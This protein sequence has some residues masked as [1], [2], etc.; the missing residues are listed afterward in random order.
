MKLDIPSFL[1]G[2]NSGIGSGGY[3]K[4]GELGRNAS[5]LHSYDASKVFLKDS[6]FNDWA[7]STT[8]TTLDNGVAYDAITIDTTENDFIVLGKWHTHFE[9]AS[10]AEE[11]ARI[12]DLYTSIAHGIR[13]FPNTIANMDTETISSILVDA[14]PI[15][16]NIIDY[17]NS[18]G[19]HTITVGN[20]GVYPQWLSPTAS[21]TGIIAKTPIV[22]GKCGTASFSTTSAGKVDKNKSYYEYKIDVWKVDKWTSIFG[23]LIEDSV[24]MWKEQNG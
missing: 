22:K 4:N 17:F 20:A 16:G 8:E 1:F 12:E 11:K 6:G 18:S 3:P 9:Y 13:G 21:V 24:K 7:P 5:I 14:S 23:K 15:G 19:T 2:L 10:D